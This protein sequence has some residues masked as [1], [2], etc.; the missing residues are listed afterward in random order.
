VDYEVI[1]KLRD[2]RT[3][4]ADWIRARQTGL[5]GT[6]ASSLCGHNPWKSTTTLFAEKVTAD[7]PVDTAA[8]SE[9]AYWGRTLE[10]V[11]AEEFSR[12]EPD[13]VP[14]PADVLLRSV[15]H[16]CMLATL[17]FWVFDRRTQRAEDPG[18]WEADSFLECKTTA[19]YRGRHWKAGVMPPYV[20]AQVLHY[21]AVTGFSHAWVACLVGGQNFVYLRYERDE[22][23]VRRLVELEESFWGYV[24]RREMPPDPFCLPEADPLGRQTFKAGETMSLLVLPDGVEALVDVYWA[25]AELAARAAERRDEALASLE[26][27][28]YGAHVGIAGDRELLRWEGTRGKRRLV[29]ARP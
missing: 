28:L 22:A 10:P 7:S 5:G 8:A 25:S 27:L 26:D 23:A 1:L 3:T 9:A 11:V 18:T 21:L 15:E 14:T 6:D 12:R 2:G 16:P 13:L 20:E 24:E 29:V 4:F 17:D 19:W